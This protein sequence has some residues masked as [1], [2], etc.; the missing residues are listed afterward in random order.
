MAKTFDPVGMEVFKNSLETVADGMALTVLLASR[1]PNVRN[2]MDFSTAVLTPD[3]EM[4]AQG[5][6]LAIHLGGMM[7][8]LRSCLDRYK[9]RIY[10]GDIMANNDPYE[11]GSHLPDI[12]LFKPVFAGDVLLGFMCAMSHH[13]DI[14]GRVAGGSACDST[15]I[16]QEGLRIPPMKLYERGEPN[17][18][19]FRVLEKAVRVPDLVLGDVRGQVTALNWGEH[20]YL[21]LVEQLGVEEMQGRIDE[22]FTYTEQLTRSLIRGLPNGQWRFTDYVDDDGLGVGPI[23]IVV[24]LTKEDDE[25]HVDFKGTGSQCKGA[26]NVPFGTSQGMVYGATKSVLGTLGAEIPNASG[27]FRP[28]TVTAPEGTFVNPLPPAPVAARGLGCVR[29]FQTVLGAFAQMLPNNISACSGGAEF[30]CTIAGYDK[31]KVPWKPWVVMDMLS[32]VAWGGFSDKD[33]NDGL[34]FLANN[35]AI[36]PSETVDL[37]SHFRV[38]GCGFVTDSE[39]AGKFRGGMGMYRTQRYLRDDTLLQLR[40]DRQ[41]HQ[42]YGLWGGKPSRATQVT[43]QTHQEKRRMPGKSLTTVNKDDVFHIEVPGGGGWGDPLERDPERVLWDVI[44]EKV[45][46]ERAREVYGVVLDPEQRTI[47][48]E[49]THRLRQQMRQSS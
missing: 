35:P 37:E 11:G 13:T 49:A 15:E 41:E 36:V 34:H 46:P 40:S 19:L 27:Y 1:S 20:H 42:P 43:L 8:A 26:L 48:W 9:G 44:E 5:A 7:P 21:R 32:E 25:I 16:Y 22:L 28:V 14:G 17:E 47:D 45:T 39:G 23:P 38:E 6:C 18:T 31:E 29:I 2:A 33:G 10:P 24:T 3:G 12:Y 30:M 4:A